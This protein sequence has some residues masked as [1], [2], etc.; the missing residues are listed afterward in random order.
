MPRFSRKFSVQFY[1]S[2]AESDGLL[3][4]PFGRRSLLDDSIAT[5]C[6]PRE[7]DC[8]CAHRA[9]VDFLQANAQLIAEYPLMPVWDG[10]SLLLNALNQQS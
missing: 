2:G 1:R 9:I 6:E 4:V 3:V 5:V 8:A 10:A 7:V